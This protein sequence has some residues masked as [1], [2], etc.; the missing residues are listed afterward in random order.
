MWDTGHSALAIVAMESEIFSRLEF[1]L[2]HHDSL[3]LVGTMSGLFP[4]EPWAMIG[5]RATETLIDLLYG[6]CVRSV[7]LQCLVRAKPLCSP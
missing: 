2:Y 5:R 6:A 7:E 1:D 3:G 4:E